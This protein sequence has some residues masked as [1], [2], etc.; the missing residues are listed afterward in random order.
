M[1][2][3]LDAGA[4]YDTFVEESGSQT[5]SREDFVKEV[6]VLTDPHRMQADLSRMTMERDRKRTLEMLEKRKINKALEN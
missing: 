5:M 1:R 6:G 3:R 2:K 4:I